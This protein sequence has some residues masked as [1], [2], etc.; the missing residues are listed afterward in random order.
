MTAGLLKESNPAAGETV[1][2]DAAEGKKT[3][4]TKKKKTMRRKWET[5]AHE[6]FFRR[7][8]FFTGRLLGGARFP[9]ATGGD[10]KLFWFDRKFFI[11]KAIDT[12]IVLY[13]CPIF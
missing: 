5:G 11:P 12:E 13:I 8:L 2:F 10:I 1:F 3:V 4:R 7:H 9:A 6:I